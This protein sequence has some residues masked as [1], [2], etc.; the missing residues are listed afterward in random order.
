MSK[1]AIYHHFKSKEEILQTIIDKKVNREKTLLHDL[2]ARTHADNARE[3][4]SKI[5]LAFLAREAD[6]FHGAPK[7]LILSTVNDPNI[8]IA[9][10]QNAVL[11]MAPVISKLFAEGAQDG[12]IK[13]D[14]PL[15]YAEIFM[16]LFSTWIKPTLFNRDKQQTQQRLQALKQLMALLGIDI[17]S[18]AMIEK[19]LAFYQENELV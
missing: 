14:Y 15:E 8:V 18:E 16:L 10:L 17:I 4:I 2:A 7:S 9:T 6:A 3:K 13:T 11:D 1:G 12:S 5:L 19:A